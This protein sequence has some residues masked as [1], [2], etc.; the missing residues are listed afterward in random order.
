MRMKPQKIKNKLKI[1]MMKIWIL[2]LV[3][4][5]CVH[6]YSGLDGTQPVC[7]Q[8]EVL[9]VFQNSCGTTGCHDANSRAHGLDLTS[10]AS[11]MEGV[12]PYNAAESH[13]YRAMTGRWE[14]MPPSGPVSKENRTKIWLWIEQGAPETICDSNGN[15]TGVTYAC[16]QRD[17]LPVLLNSC[18]LSGCHDNQSHKEGI[19]LTS[20]QN[21][22]NSGVVK[23]NKPQNS[24]L[25]QAITKNTSSEDIMPP[26]PY[27]PLSQAVKDTIYNWI[28]RGAKNEI[29]V[30]SCDTTGTIS[31][32]GHINGIISTNCLSC[33]SGS[34]PNGGIMLSSYT[35][36]M[37]VAKTGKLAASVKRLS[38]SKPM[39]PAVSL[40]KCDIRKIELWIKQNFPQ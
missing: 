22:V 15:V 35:N 9:P 4:S 16:F 20:Y 39:P 13:V 18:A 19:N 32:S 24:T 6:E 14:V 12:K 25:Y 2:S 30:T 31:W 36:V 37:N 34:S 26:K 3:L 1:R 40:T 33:H 8:T 10:Y 5:G 38:S 7:F 27:S 28:I 23:A 21:M 17:V 11:V 29:C